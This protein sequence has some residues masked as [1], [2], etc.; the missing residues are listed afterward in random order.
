MLALNKISES[1][2]IVH[3]DIEHVDIE[4]DNRH[5]NRRAHPSMIESFNSAINTLFRNVANVA[6]ASI[7]IYYKLR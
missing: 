7:H 6:S 1:S 2:D 5:F 3:V 4:I